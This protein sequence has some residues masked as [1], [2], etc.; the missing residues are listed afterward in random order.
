MTENIYNT[1]AYKIARSVYIAIGGD[2]NKNF[3]S[4]EDIYSDIDSI[5]DVNTGRVTVE[6]LNL[7]ITENGSHYIDNQ[8]IT[9]YKPVSVN[10][11]IPSGLVYSGLG[12]RDEFL[13]EV[14]NN[15]KWAVDK[16]VEFK[17]AW[18]PDKTAVSMNYDWAIYLPSLG[19]TSNVKTIYVPEGLKIIG[20]NTFNNYTSSSTPFYGKK[21]LTSVGNLSFPLIST[22]EGYFMNDTVLQTVG[23]FSAENATSGSS[24]FQWCGTLKKVGDIYLPSITSC[25]GMFDGCYELQEIGKLTLG[26]VQFATGMFK[27]CEKLRE[28]PEF[29]ASTITNISGMFSQCKLLETIP[30]LDFSNVMYFSSDFSYCNEL[31]N[32]G[33]FKNMGMQAEGYW[34]Y[35]FDMSYCSKL[36]HESMLNIVNNLYDRR[37]AGY[38]DG[39]I[40]FHWD[41]LN[42][43]TAEEKAIATNKGW[44]LTS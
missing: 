19:D 37:S 28:I 31:K 11:N 16:C 7:N 23:N 40:K 2:P 41:A 9:G 17:N 26:P 32:V 6:P 4:V 1:P 15:E 25:Q 24:L 38:T 29:D 43:L 8:D 35:N 3:D 18:T 20:D 5:F 44:A 34:S 13:T 42:R 21:N 36:T 30:L 14:Y 12:Y 22:A 27:Y 10:V 39:K 33:G